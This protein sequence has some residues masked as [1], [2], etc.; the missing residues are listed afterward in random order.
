MDNVRA[1][2]GTAQ[3]VIIRKAYRNE[4][5]RALMALYGWRK[6]DDDCFST[7]LFD[8]IA[9]ADSNNLAKLR[10]GFPDEVGAFMEWYE[11]PDE[12]VFLEDIRIR[13]YNR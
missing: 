2:G 10:R 1:V 12:V 9:K 4:R 13:L 6:F 11:S 7:M 8:L 5:E 3:R